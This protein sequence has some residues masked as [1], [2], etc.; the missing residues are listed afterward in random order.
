MDDP[1]LQL[2]KEILSPNIKL[3]G[4]ILGE[5]I[6]E[7]NG[8]ESL[9]LEEDVR[10]LT[11]EFREIGNSEALIQSKRIIEQLNL[12]NKNLLIRAFSIFFQLANLAEEDYRIH[13]N[14]TYKDTENDTLTHMIQDIRAYNLSPEELILLFQQIHIRLVWTAHPTEARRMSIMTKL[15]QIFQLIEKVESYD[16]KSLDYHFNRKRIKELVTLLWQSDDLREQKVKVLDEVRTGLFYFESTIFETLP[17]LYMDLEVLLAEAYPNFDWSN[18]PTFLNFGSWVGGDRDGHPGVTSEITIQTL[19]LHK[20]LCL[21]KYID[22]VNTLIQDLS[23]ST[24]LVPISEELRV[25]LENETEKFTDFAK[26][27]SSLN[28]TEPYRRKLDF[29][30]LKLENTLERVE[31]LAEQVGLGR[32]LVGS[33]LMTQINPDYFIYYKRSTEFL[34][35]LN[36]LRKSLTENKASIIAH[37]ELEFIIKQVNIFGFHLAPL[38]LRQHS[39]R[40]LETVS[41]IFHFIGVQDFDKL[42]FEDKRDILLKELNNLRPL[43]ALFNL[44]NFSDN[45]KEI[46]RTLLV[47]K[48]SIETISPRVIDSYIISMSKDETD[49]YN[50]MLLMKEIGL[51]KIKDGKA[52]FG[53]IDIVPLFETKLDLENAPEVMDRLYSDPLYRSYINLKQ[54]T[55]EIMIGYS[56]SMKDAGFLQSNFMLIQA[57]L[58]LKEVADKHGVKLRIF[59][60]RGGSI[61]RGGGPTHKSILGQLPETV[62]NIKITEQGEVIGF[63]YANKLIAYRH[64]E[65]IVSAGVYR[66]VSD[67][68]LP[69]EQNKAYNYERYFSVL[70][71]LASTSYITYEK[72]VKHD[73]EFLKFYQEFTPLDVIERATIGSRPSRRGIGEVKGIEDLRAIPWVFSWMQ[74]RLIFTAYYGA[75]TALR[76]FISQKGIS[77]LKEIYTEW[78]FFQSLI[79]NLQMICTKVDIDIAKQYL[80]LCLTADV[81]IFD[82]ISEEYDKTKASILELVGEKELLESAPDIRNSVLRRNPYTDPLNLIQV[83]LVKEWRSKG[84]PDDLSSTGLL[85]SLLQTVNGIAAGLKNTG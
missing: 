42:G 26:Y 47:A 24:S 39:K 85:R 5:V 52:I 4:D 6:V 69:R 77:T 12:G 65:Q 57:Q 17:K 29:M 75:G 55:Q 27:T 46:I 74:T 35:D 43:G 62:F 78:P 1:R 71:E 67:I 28:K 40:H 64:L 61:S 56:D 2:S 82:Q 33:H 15:R 8:V 51:I 76:T 54:N 10:K 36:I 20:R 49:V 81:K 31:E 41:E 63:N 22:G 11:K 21:R 14:N 60:G 59:H 13:V 9:E 25:N 84:K 30:R 34:E 73:P 80:E 70:K 66:C 18:L 68:K 48:Q 38:D 72:L 23:I 7:Q 83:E 37:G 44:N 58:R 19:L 79:D 16:S 50:L 3:F 53:L 32:T 45:V